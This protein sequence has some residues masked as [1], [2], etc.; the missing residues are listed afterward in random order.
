MKDS[1]RAGVLLR[2]LRDVL[3]VAPWCAAQVATFQRRP[4]AYI[5]SSHGATG[6]RLREV[7]SDPFGTCARLREL[8]VQRRKPHPL[9]L[10]KTS[11]PTGVSNSYPPHTWGT[12]ARWQRRC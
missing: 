11:A 4:L 12:S 10:C 5:V 9:E 1:T 6:A 2:A 3:T 7:L 8:C